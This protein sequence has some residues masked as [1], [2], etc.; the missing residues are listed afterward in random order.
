M[1]SDD[2]VTLF[3]YVEKCPKCGYPTSALQYLKTVENK[4]KLDGIH[5]GLSMVAKMIEPLLKT[6]IT[7]MNDDCNEGYDDACKFILKAIRSKTENIW[8]KN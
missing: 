4:W 6:P 8:P 3:E 2:M 1:N 7:D 5:E